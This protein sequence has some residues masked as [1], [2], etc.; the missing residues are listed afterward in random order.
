MNRIGQVI[1][2]VRM[3]QQNPSM[4]GKYLA[5]RGVITQE[6]FKEI[7][8]MNPSQV[9]QYLM[10]KGVMPQQNVQQAFSILPNI[11]NKL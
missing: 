2:D 5:D 11:Q 1:N 10:Q 9:G 4:L 6:Q 3:L 8:N 7:G